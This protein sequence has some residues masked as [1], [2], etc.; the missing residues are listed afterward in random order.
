[1]KI[2]SFIPATI[3]KKENKMGVR[4]FYN[5]FLDLLESHSFTEKDVIEINIRYILSK[6]SFK[7]FQSYTSFGSKDSL[8]NNYGNE[9]EMQNA[10]NYVTQE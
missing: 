10:N 3:F 9:S 5:E 4:N 2:K 7:G 6:E 1:M 8:M